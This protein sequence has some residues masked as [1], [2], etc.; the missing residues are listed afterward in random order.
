MKW[1]CVTGIQWQCHQV[2]KS[3]DFGVVRRVSQST[4]W[5]FHSQRDSVRAQGSAH[6]LTYCIHF[7]DPSDF[8]SVAQV[9]ER[10]FNFGIL[11]QCQWLWRTKTDFWYWTAN[12]PLYYLVWSDDI[13]DY[14]WCLRFR[15]EFT[16]SVRLFLCYQLE[17]QSQIGSN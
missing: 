4:F 3:P 5:F 12:E 7:Q 16:S 2:S 9:S 8:P 11:R 6:L 17:Y 15:W 1:G 13:Q 14:Q 10:S